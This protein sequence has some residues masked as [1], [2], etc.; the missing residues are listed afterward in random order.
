M[1]EVLEVAIDRPARQLHHPVVHQRRD[2]DHGAAVLVCLPHLD[3]RAHRRLGHIGHQ[4]VEFPAHLDVPHKHLARPAPVVRDR[5]AMIGEGVVDLRIRPVRLHEVA[6]RVPIHLVV[7]QRRHVRALHDPREK[8]PHEKSFPENV[9]ETV[10]ET[11][12]V[13]L[14]QCRPRGRKNARTNAALGIDSGRCDEARSDG[15]PSHGARAARHSRRIGQREGRRRPDREAAAG[16]GLPGR[17][18]LV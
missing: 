8:N 2:R 18:D 1:G 12:P 14:R 11:C 17:R 15:G 13:C 16:G 10:S 9:G 3:G 5:I 6:K 4:Q 7:H